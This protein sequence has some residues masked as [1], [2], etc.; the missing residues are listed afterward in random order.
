M[1]LTISNSLRD[2]LLNGDA[3]LRVADWLVVEFADGHIE[4]T[5]TRPL[6][7]DGVDYRPC[8]IAA[9]EW[10]LELGKGPS[11]LPR[12]RGRFVLTNLSEDD[13]QRF[14][15]LLARHDCLPL[16]AEFGRIYRE[17]DLSSATSDDLFVIASCFVE[18]VKLDGKRA[19]LGRRSLGYYL[20]GTLV[21]RFAY[22]VGDGGFAIVRTATDNHS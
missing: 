4:R 21:R 9:E 22:C 18:E 3:H 19:E 1:P 17:G 20:P 14:Q 13:V 12:F 8:L 10:S 6:R 7:V 16:R 11:G 15:A 2:A 5:A